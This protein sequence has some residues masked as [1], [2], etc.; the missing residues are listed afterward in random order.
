MRLVDT[1]TLRLVSL[2]DSSLPPYAILSHTWGSDDDE[3]SFQELQELGATSRLRQQVA[4]AAGPF[5][6]PISKKIGFAKIRDAAR[7]AKSQ[8]FGYIWIDTCC[9]NKTSSAELS[10][11]I[12]S[13]FRWYQEASVC[14]AF[15]NDVDYRVGDDV[16]D[17]PFLNGP[18]PKVPGNVPGNDTSSGGGDGDG[19]VPTIVE[20]MRHSRWF[21]RGW[22][23][24]ELIAPA[25]V[26]FYSKSWSLLGTKLGS[27]G[28]AGQVNRFPEL[29]SIITG[30]DLE[31]LKGRIGLDDLSVASRMKWAAKRETT[32][33]EDKAYCLM[34][35]F[36]VNMPLLYGEGNRAFI[37]LQE[38]ILKL[39]TDH[40]IFA[41]K[42]PWD[43]PLR[44]QLCGLL[45]TSPSF[46]ADADY[47]SATRAMTGV[48]APSTMT[49]AGLHIRVY[50]KQAPA[51]SEDTVQGNESQARCLAVLDC[52]PYP[53]AYGMALPAILLT[54]LGGDQYARI[55]PETILP[56]PIS[57]GEQELVPGD[58]DG[59]QYIYVK[60]LPT[61]GLPDIVLDIDSFS[62]GFPID[63]VCLLDVYH[64]KNWSAA[65]WTLKPTS[66]LQNGV[67]GVFRYAIG[68]DHGADIFV[69]LSPG[70]IG[71]R[72]LW[73]AQQVASDSIVNA[74][75]N[76]DPYKVPGRGRS[77]QEHAYLHVM[78][79]VQTMRFRN[80]TSIHLRLSQVHQAP[81]TD[82]ML[83]A[84]LGGNDAHES[85]SVTATNE[86]FASVAE[87][88]T[89]PDSWD[90][91][92]GYT[93]DPQRLPLTQSRVRVRQSRLPTAPPLASFPFLEA[94]A[95]AAG[96]DVILEENIHPS[97]SS[98]AGSE[99]W[100]QLYFSLLLAKSCLRNDARAVAELLTSPLST[101][102]VE[103]Q[104][105]VSPP[106][107]DLGLEPSAD[108]FRGFRPIHWAAAR[109]YRDIVRILVEHGADALAAT[110][111]RLTALHLAILT[112]REDIVADLLELVPADWEE[113][114]GDLFEKVY[115]REPISHLAACYVHSDLVVRVLDRFME[116]AAE[117]GDGE[118]RWMN[119][120]VNALG[121]TALHR[122]A[123]MGNV[124]AA[125][126]ILERASAV[127]IDAEDG[128]GRTP[129][130]HAAAA[131]T[132]EVVRLLLA[133]MATVRHPDALG[134]T[135]LHAACRGGHA[136]VV[137]LLLEAGAWTGDQPV[138][139]TW[140]PGVVSPLHFAVFSGH[141][142]TVK[143]M[144][145]LGEDPDKPMKHPSSAT[146][147]AIQNAVANNLFEVVKLLCER[148]CVTD[149]SLAQREV[150]VLDAKGETASLMVFHDPTL[151]SLAESL[152]FVRVANYL[153]VKRLRDVRE[154]LELRQQERMQQVPVVAETVKE[155]E[156][157]SES[158]DDGSSDLP[159]SRA[160]SPEPEEGE[161]NEA[162]QA[163]DVGE[164]VLQEDS[165][166]KTWDSSG[167]DPG[168]VRPR[169]SPREIRR[170]AI[171]G[172]PPTF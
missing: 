88:L 19:G 132:V 145:D 87:P 113:T 155:D 135:P 11:A 168:P 27:F 75:K 106:A 65:N 71:P 25:D 7:L 17:Y 162:E 40:S 125:E 30:I 26:R 117:T 46:F 153:N 114:E 48:S 50:L 107:T 57:H 90:L 77:L 156:V 14:Y 76:F 142:E 39:T 172:W 32:R 108:V 147:T 24:Q 161:E 96:Q 116:R 98:E 146:C 70:Y 115:A 1:S 144:L 55:S 22:T 84:E 59:Y 169:G 80:R 95:F 31:L 34:G 8:G 138:Y 160:V 120:R 72:E 129:L 79:Q 110:A 93:S 103:V 91:S 51:Q 41:W 47:K 63:P 111:G 167:S 165:S 53:V 124:V 100:F 69:G 134:R 67:L 35:I 122:A 157:S 133:R 83:Y 15:L 37:R 94:I 6:H 119:T 143:L 151:L 149:L 44:F 148:G 58:G 60:Q 126:A 49:N 36:G 130:W 38:E 68:G 164:T 74:A 152:R 29:I 92:L 123:A 52:S 13:M 16:R 56:V 5:S 104:T 62:L 82:V 140:V 150:L 23:L 170:R 128:N 112:G 102:R 97:S 171:A 54:S 33:I 10:E 118:R 109:G 105:R 9:I 86:L 78:A 136:S 131:G 154:S 89:L 42:C 4:A 12:N 101:A 81:D 137:A 141:A 28:T 2:H 45:A 139:S 43:D 66:A 127:G 61:Y 18:S 166:E 121:E 99:H 3:V 64:R 159:G 163:E 21:T 73:V 158:E 85:A 20:V